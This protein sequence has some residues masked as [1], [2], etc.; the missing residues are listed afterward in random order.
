MH[1]ER[2]NMHC[3]GIAYSVSFDVG[4]TLAEGQKVEFFNDQ[5]IIFLKLL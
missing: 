5:Q 1:I 4:L 3:R 2:A